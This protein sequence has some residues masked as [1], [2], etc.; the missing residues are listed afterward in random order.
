MN[1]SNSNITT[2]KT[3]V[4]THP[5]YDDHDADESDDGNYIHLVKQ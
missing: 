3:N 2:P 4:V 1:G 5:E